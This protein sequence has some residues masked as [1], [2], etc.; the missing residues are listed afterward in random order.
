M[1]KLSELRFIRLIGLAGKKISTQIATRKNG[2]PRIIFDK[3]ASTCCRQVPLAHIFYCKLLPIANRFQEGRTFP[4][5]E[6]WNDKNENG[7]QSS[8]E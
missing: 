8:L 2:F 7:F 4:A 1:N 3:G 6:V 5:I